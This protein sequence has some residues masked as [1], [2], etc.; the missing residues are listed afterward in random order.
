MLL[1]TSLQTNK[2]GIV[3]LKVFSVDKA[4][5]ILASN[6]EKVLPVVEHAVLLCQYI[7][8]RKEN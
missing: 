7:E 2:T 3:I 6:T 8:I 1:N 4:K 5:Y